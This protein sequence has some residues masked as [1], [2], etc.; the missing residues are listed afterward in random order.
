M[1]SAAS[2]A[3]VIVIGSADESILPVSTGD[4]SSSHGNRLASQDSVADTAMMGEVCRANPS[5][6]VFLDNQ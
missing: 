3:Q 4:E 6:R 2:S 1:V 5:L